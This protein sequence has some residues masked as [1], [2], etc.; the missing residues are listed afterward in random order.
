MVPV[1]VR[2][3]DADVMKRSEESN[4]T[5]IEVRTSGLEGNFTLYSQQPANNFFSADYFFLPFFLEI[6]VN[7]YRDQTFVKIHHNKTKLLF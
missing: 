5:I 4:E 2:F 1:Q 3:H 6:F 7:F